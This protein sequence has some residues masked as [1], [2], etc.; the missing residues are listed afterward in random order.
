MVPN[1]VSSLAAL[2]QRGLL[3]LQVAEPR[4]RD[5]GLAGVGWDPGNLATHEAPQVSGN[6]YPGLGTGFIRESRGFCTLH[7]QRAP[8]LE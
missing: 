5:V 8:A 7:V 1:P 6:A 2:N 3:N 4:H